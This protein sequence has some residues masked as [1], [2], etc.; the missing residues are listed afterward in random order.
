MKKGRKRYALREEGYFNRKS[1]IEVPKMIQSVHKVH[2]C[3]SH[4]GQVGKIE[5]LWEPTESERS[6]AWDMYVEIVTRIP[7]AFV[8][9]G[10][11]SLHV[12]LASTYKIFGATRDILRK[13]GPAVARPRAEGQISFGCLSVKVLDL[14]LRPFLLRWYPRLT[15]YESTRQATESTYDHE[16]K[17]DCYQE[18]SQELIQIRD[19]LLQ[20][21]SLLAQA[22]EV[23]SLIFEK[24]W[25]GKRIT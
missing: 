9:P 1:P 25:P 2:I 19:S 12:S 14:I 24:E 7:V 5:G 20:Y 16:R 23:P 11:G 13:Y 8:V 22:S 3:Y 21:A 6:A 10:E 18:L 17:W 15:E 4:N